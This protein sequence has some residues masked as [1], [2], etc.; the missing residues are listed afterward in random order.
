[1][2]VLRLNGSY[3]GGLTAMPDPASSAQI[4]FTEAGI[5]LAKFIKTTAIIPWYAVTAL[6]TETAGKTCRI[7]VLCA[8]PFE[9]V[10]AHGAAKV[11]TQVAGW[12]DHIGRRL[13]TPS[14]AQAAAV[15]P[16]ASEATDGDARDGVLGQLREVLT[17]AAQR[18][19]PTA[20]QPAVPGGRPA[21]D[22][23]RPAQPQPAPD[24]SVAVIP[25]RRD[26]AR[27]RKADQR[28]ECGY[29]V[30]TLAGVTL[31]SRGISGPKT[32]L[33]PLKKGTEAIVDTAAGVSSRVT[34]TRLLAF[35]VFALAAPK[36]SGELYL[37]ITGPDVSIV[38][39]VD[40][41]KG[42]KARQFAAQVN[43]AARAAAV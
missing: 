9:F 39:Q 4:R 25:S 38:V 6:E 32:P 23:V 10:V 28:F 13:P 36:R 19:T 37:L 34:A 17:Q 2:S 20:A 21:Q 31:Y 35:G 11:V 42:L 27:Q 1:M 33:Q 7:R 15:M 30:A 5:E 29:P 3:C 8:Q 43:A 24:F 12:R 41:K 40:P 18:P 16:D 26:A 22:A 14:A